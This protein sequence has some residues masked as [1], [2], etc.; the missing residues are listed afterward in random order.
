MEMNYDK[1]N[2]DVKFINPNK[3][4]GIYVIYND[5]Y[6][7]VGQSNNVKNRW[8]VHRHKL[9]YNKHDNYIMQQVYNKFSSED[10]FRYKI[11][12]ECEEKDL[13]KLEILI[14][15]KL[16]IK[17]SKKI[18][19]NIANCG[20][21]HNWTDE[22]RKKASEV[23]K[24]R[25]TPEEVK[26]KISE[27]QKG[28]PREYARVSIVQLTLEGEF[29]KKWDSIKEAQKYLGK[30]INLNEKTSGGY[31]WQRYKEYLEC[32]KGAI[33]IIKN[34]C[35]ISQ[36]SKDG[37]YIQTFNSMYEAQKQTGISQGSIDNV[38]KGIQKSAGG[39]IW[40]RN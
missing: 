13:D 18:C 23:R 11:V 31:Q 7:Y 4:C 27:A 40:K 15:E 6:F 24:G 5:T 38:I 39:F 25:K 9:K 17:Y 33:K 28:K 10:P 1:I 30:R 20:G 12:C 22:M 2:D 26:K 32:P 37:E 35:P 19:M 21:R 8:T 3:I 34:R 16:C 36:Y 14:K 29:V